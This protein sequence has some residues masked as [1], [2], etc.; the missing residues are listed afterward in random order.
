MSAADT[1][2][3]ID[4]TDPVLIIC[5]RIYRANFLARSLQMNDRIIGT[6]LGTHAAFLTLC[7][8][9]MHADL[10][11]RYCVKLAAALAGLAETESAVIRNGV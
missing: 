3:F 4:L 2:L 5:D 11:G 7:R 8:I 9:Y 1:L 10:T 6:A